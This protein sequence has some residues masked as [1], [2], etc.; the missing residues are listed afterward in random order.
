MKEKLQV[1]G[2]ITEGAQVRPFCGI[3]IRNAGSFHHWNNFTRVVFLKE[4]VVRR[5]SGQWPSMAGLLHHMGTSLGFLSLGRGAVTMLLHNSVVW[6]I[7]S[8]LYKCWCSGVVKAELVKWS[9][10]I[11]NK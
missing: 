1:A 4:M 3:K 5:L 8:T 7:M 2:P 9:N 6:V 10:P 11:D